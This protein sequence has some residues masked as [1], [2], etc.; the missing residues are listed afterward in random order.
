MCMLHDHSQTHN[1]GYDSSG[2]VISPTYRT[3]PNNT[4]HSQQADSN[5]PRGI[6]TRKP[7]KTLPA[8]PR[9]RSRSQWDCPSYD[10]RAVDNRYIA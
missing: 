1:T 6:R 9:L 3:L 8:D 2:R 5:A 4:Q 10:L 7:S